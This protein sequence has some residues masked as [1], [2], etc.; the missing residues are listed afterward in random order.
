MR[1][2]TKKNLN[3]VF[4]HTHRQE[5]EIFPSCL[6]L[7]IPNP[8][9]NDCVVEHRDR[10]RSCIFIRASASPLVRLCRHLKMG[11]GIIYPISCFFGIFVLFFIF[12]TPN[13]AWYVFWLKF[14]NY[15]TCFKRCA[16]V[17]C[18]HVI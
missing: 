10:P 17:N 8:L 2:K 14:L 18:S 3:F 5:G 16:G 11:I 9:L 4:L 12:V 15:S 7:L 13:R 1:P 6:V